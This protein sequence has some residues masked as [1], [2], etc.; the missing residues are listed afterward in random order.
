[1]S[2]RPE[3][4]LPQTKTRIRVA[5]KRFYYIVMYMNFIPSSVRRE[6]TISFISFHF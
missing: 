4:H 1:M 2:L 5:I 3:A 6:T